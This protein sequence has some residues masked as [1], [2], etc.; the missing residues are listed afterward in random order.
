MMPAARIILAVGLM[1]PPPALAL[2]L[3]FGGSATAPMPPRPVVSIV[4]VDSPAARRVI[5]GVIKARTEVMLG[6][7][8]LGRIRQRDVDLGDRVQ[9]G[10]V[11]ARL[12]PDD[13]N[14]NVR[15]AE[16]LVDSAEVALETSAATAARTRE[17]VQRNVVPQVLLEQAAQELAAAE[18]G[19]QQARS[20]LVRARDALGF[21]TLTAPFDG[22][23]SAVF[24]NAGAVVGAGSPVMVLSDDRDPEA[25]IDLPESTLAVLPPDVS[26]DVWREGSPETRIQARILQIEPQADSATQTRRVHLDLDDHGDF[27]LGSLV[28]ARRTDDAHVLTVPIAAIFE[29]EGVPTV[30]LVRRDGATG[31]V[32]PVPVEIG[33]R[34]NGT[35]VIAGGLVE[36]D[37][38]V[39]RG[40]NSLTQG[41]LVGR[42]VRP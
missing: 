15:A 7:Q 24:E 39:I 21:A 34:V 3:P 40:V 23:I 35:A 19:L 37:E 26:F 1:L 12:D 29:H 30:W 18:A 17:L 8:T 11:L 32:D 36:G 22:V 13:L 9:K 28:Q 20:Q 5:P 25:V 42:S 31:V 6:F 10:Q 41:Q 4:V 2:D 27:R 38:V 33:T 14:A 16:A